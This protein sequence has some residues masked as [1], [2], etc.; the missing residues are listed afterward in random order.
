[1]PDLPSIDP[2][3]KALMDLPIEAMMGAWVYWKQ[4]TYKYLVMLLILSLAGYGVISYILVKNAQKTKLYNEQKVGLERVIEDQTIE[5][6]KLKA[7]NQVK[8]AEASR[9]AG[10]YVKT[11]NSIDLSIFS[12]SDWQAM[13]RARKASLGIP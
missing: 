4:V 7:E 13:V 10:N 8:I 9:T 6:N 3:R 5:I 2:D 11:I 12:N 1:M